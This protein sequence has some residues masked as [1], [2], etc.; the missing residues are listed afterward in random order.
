[1][2]LVDCFVSMVVPLRNDADIVEAF[3]AD[4]L[5]MLS[6][7]YE[8]YELVL[9]DDGSRDETPRLVDGLLAHRRHLRLVRLSR[10]FGLEIAISAGLDMVIGDYCVVMLPDS[11]PVDAVPEMIERSRRGAGIVFGV[12]ADRGVEPWWLSLGA[13]GFYWFCKNI[14]DLNLPKNTTH[15]R[16]LSRQALNAVTQ[17]RD[18]RRYLQTLSNYVGYS[19]QAFLFE[20]IQR[21]K[22]PRLKNPIEALVLAVNI[23][24]ANSLRPLRLAGWFSFAVAGLNLIY[25]GYVVAIYL[26]KTHVAEGWVTLSFQAATMSFCLFLVV[27]VLCEYLSRLLG[28]SVHR[29]L[30]YVVEQRASSPLPIDERRRNV[31]IESVEP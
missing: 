19:G 11:D 4:A 30:Y 13:S 18:Q 5:A 1:M 26:L 22:P 6:G 2:P 31:A 28:E 16:V 15:F 8:H 9:V 27:G 21:R 17:I 3:V 20:E 29:P 23:V 25:L 12:R 10:H 14:L 7:T 24:V